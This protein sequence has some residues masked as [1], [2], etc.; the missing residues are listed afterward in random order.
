MADFANAV[1]VAVG[2]ALLFGVGRLFFT[3]LTGAFATRLPY[4]WRW[5]AMPLTALISFGLF[6]V[7]RPLVL[8]K[9]TNPLGFVGLCV[10]VALLVS[11]ATAL[12]LTAVEGWKVLIAP[13]RGR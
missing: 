4:R 3:I 13:R 5:L 8:D 7:L 12:G 10:A 11:G 9:Q 2:L 1:A 6:T